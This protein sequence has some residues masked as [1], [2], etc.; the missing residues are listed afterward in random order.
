M[1]TSVNIILFGPPGAGKGTQAKMIEKEFGLKQLSTGDMLRAEIAS[2]SS[3][4]NKVKEIIDA[5]ELVPDVTMIELIS[6]R[7]D[8]PDCENGF[9]LDGFPRTLGQ[10]QALDNMLVQ[11]GKTLDAVIQIKVDEDELINRLNSRIQQQKDRGEPVRSDD[12]EETL[13]NRLQVYHDQTMPVLPHYKEK[14][15]LHEVDGMQ[16]IDDVSADIKNILTRAKAA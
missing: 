2:Q 9:I 4:G 13:K 14:G 3:L 10:A 12:N 8:H 5:G 1:S 16:S 7:I 6:N 11:K 15:V